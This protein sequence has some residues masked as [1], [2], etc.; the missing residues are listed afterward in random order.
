MAVITPLDRADIEQLVA[1]YPL[2]PV[3][4]IT[5]SQGGVENTTY[6]VSTLGAPTDNSVM[7]SEW[8]LT[9]IEYA[10]RQQV[11]FTARLLQ[12]L[13]QAGL[14]VPAPLRSR[15]G[16]LW[17]ELAGKPAWLIPRISGRHPDRIE[18]H[19]CAAVGDVLGAMHRAGEIFDT[20]HNNTR[21]LDWLQHTAPR[22]TL[23]TDQRALL[24]RQVDRWQ[25]LTRTPLPTGPI[26]GDLFH[27]NALFDGSRLVG[28]IDFLFCCTDWLLLDVAIAVNDWCAEPDGSI[29][30][31]RCHAL[32]AAYSAHRPFTVAEHH[33]WREVL[34]LAATRFWVSRLV[35]ARTADTPTTAKDPEPYRRMV[36]QRLQAAPDL[37]LSL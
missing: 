24:Q 21:G 14:P 12:H 30:A 26:H 11:A 19:H 6:F 29:D 7:E 36:E 15:D 16:Q 2:G 4:T 18:P 34:A 5:P 31:Q 3:T 25:F 9:L 23:P 37:P 1:R 13:A 32:L 27:D 33:H 17:Q 35:T 28:I 10:D 20:V 8:V 22:L